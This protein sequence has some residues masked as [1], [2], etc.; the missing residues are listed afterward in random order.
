MNKTFKLNFITTL[1]SILTLA[2]FMPLTLWAES[3]KD[4]ECPDVAALTDELNERFD[5]LTSIQ[6]GLEN[7][8]SAKAIKY[9]GTGALFLV[10]LNNDKAVAKRIEELKT[11]AQNRQN[12][13]SS[14]DAVLNCALNHEQTR[15]MRESI[16][17]IQTQIDALRLQFLQLPKAKRKELLQISDQMTEQKEEIETIQNEQI[18]SN[19]RKQQAINALEKAETEA[20]TEKSADLQELASQRTIL[21][22]TKMDIEDLHAKWRSQQ[23]KNILYYQELLKKIFEIKERVHPEPSLNA[24]R[25]D[26]QDIVALWRAS[27]DDIMSGKLKIRRPYIPELPEM[28]LQLIQKIHTTR[29]AREYTTSYHEAVANRE[30][31]VAA[32]TEGAKQNYHYLSQIKLGAMRAKLL[33]QMAS[34]G[35]TSPFNYSDEY[36]K[37]LKRELQTIPLR[38]KLILSFLIFKYRQAYNAGLEDKFQLVID[39]LLVIGLILS[40]FIGWTSVKKIVLQLHK[41]RLYLIAKRNAFFLAAPLALWIQRIIPYLPWL[42]LLPIFEIGQRLMMLYAIDQFI[43][44]L[45]LIPYAQ[46]YCIYRIVRLLLDS[47]FTGIAALSN[48]Y[49]TNECEVKMV[50]TVALV[51]W[52]IVIAAI[53]LASVNAIL[54]KGFIYRLC[55]QTTTIVSL[56]VLIA[57]AYCWNKELLSIVQSVSSHVYVEKFVHAFQSR[58]GKA[59]S[60]IPLALVVIVIIFKELQHW[61]EEFEF[62]KKMSAK[63]YKRK[64]KLSQSKTTETLQRNVPSEYAKWFSSDIPKELLLTPKKDVLPDVKQTV[65][66]WVEGRSDNARLVIYGDKGIG[67]TALLN[68]LALEITD[69]PIVRIQLTN[70]ITTAPEALS[71]VNTLLNMNASSESEAIAEAC[72]GMPK[73]L[74]I[75]DDAHNL[76]L[77]KIGGFEGI[78]AFLRMVNATMKKIFWCLVLNRYS[79]NYLNSIAGYSQYGNVVKAV[80][81]WTEEDIKRLILTRHNA[82]G[83]LLSYEDIIKAAGVHNGFNGVSH[84]ESNF[85]RILWQQSSG[86][87]AVAIASWLSALYGAG[88]H[89]F[90]VMLP[91]EYKGDVLEG[92][93]D[94]SFFVFKE[95]I[96]HE[97][98]TSDQASEV[99]NLPLNS[100]NQILVAGALNKIVDAYEDGSYCVSSSYLYPLINQLKVKNFVDGY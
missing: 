8:L 35:D 27:L 74:A 16:L 99:T 98:L 67:K 97:H 45:F 96:R 83:Y 2:L 36:V 64:F 9:E 31:F 11:L 19:A 93:S 3:V 39:F 80:S 82:T 22:K 50:R 10:D 5:N 34:M 55:L 70:K 32:I 56:G 95:I 20:V 33:N 30:R 51:S 21:E 73:T 46:V 48:C 14:P 79:W 49:L 13:A 17:A 40:L 43:A 77:A 72:Q 7:L 15:R 78:R 6:T 100:V 26:Y 87:P 59:F 63:A 60:F 81:A 94:N 4:A 29:Q 65:M 90:K 37:D 52:F 57:T 66:S 1:L 23:E 58:L 53:F 62:Y 42:L 84:I 54:Y 61:G 41:L 18:Q 28:P 68:R 44:P 88:D 91:E 12:V 47:L 89:S 71:A 24:L 85:F 38:W 25:Q 69:I 76:F 86:N 75:V 92:L